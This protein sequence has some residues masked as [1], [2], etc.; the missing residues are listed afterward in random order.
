M[1]WKSLNLSLLLTL[2]SSKVIPFSDF[3]PQVTLHSI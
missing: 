2:H 1:V 3:S